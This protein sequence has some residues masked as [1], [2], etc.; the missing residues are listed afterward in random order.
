M[1]IIG[2]ENDS[3]D[4]HDSN[5]ND[6]SNDDGNKTIQYRNIS[7]QK[8]TV[9]RAKGTPDTRGTEQRRHTRSQDPVPYWCQVRP[10]QDHDKPKRIH[11]L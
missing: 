6:N 2:N 7:S 10:Q 5:Y 4:T 1:T 8:W 9:P 3:E 11:I